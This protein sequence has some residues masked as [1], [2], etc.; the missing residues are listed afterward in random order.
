ML[1]SARSDG[2]AHKV[3]IVV[4]AGYVHDRD[5]RFLQQWS[6]PGSPAM[7]EM[8]LVYATAAGPEY[9]RR[10]F[11]RAHQPCDVRAGRDRI[12]LRREILPDGFQ[13]LCGFE[14]GPRARPNEAGR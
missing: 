3:S 7:W 11:A 12:E 10:N 4:P 14:E 9:A 5:T 2:A 13:V 8:D 6:R 1:S